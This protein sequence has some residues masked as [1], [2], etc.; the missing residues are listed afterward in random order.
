MFHLII[1]SV[2]LAVSRGQ[3]I[4]PGY[5][6]VCTIVDG[7]NCAGTNYKPVCGTDNVTYKTECDFAKAHCKDV[8]L[9][10]QNE[11]TCA[12][13]VTPSPATTPTQVTTPMA[14]VTSPAPASTVPTSQATPPTTTTLPTTAADTTPKPTLS[15]LCQSLMIQ[16]CP[17][18]NS[19][20]CGSDAVSYSSL[21]E[22]T[23]ARCLNPSLT[24]L[25]S[26][27]C[28]GVTTTTPAPSVNDI[29][30]RAI[31]IHTCFDDGLVLCGSD[32]I[33]YGNSCEFEKAKCRDE[34]LS[35][36]KVGPC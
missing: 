4:T 21:C 12:N 20:V 27:A 33:T 32:S 2:L 7:L 28:V 16:Q 10:V 25:N 19:P 13:P 1:L 22:Y 29:I 9:S 8:K 23:K 11:G 6:A 18:D 24:V 3:Q 14:S 31:N 15:L 35:L 17:P 30:C 26:G 34:S 36:T 5:S